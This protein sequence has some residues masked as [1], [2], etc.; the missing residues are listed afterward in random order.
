MRVRLYSTVICGRPSIF[1]TIISA[2]PSTLDIACF[3][4]SAFSASIPKSSPKILI[5]TSERVPEISSLKRISIGCVN[6]ISIFGMVASSSSFILSANSSF[7]LADTHSL[8]GFIFTI[9]SLSSI[10][11]GSVGTSAAPIRLTIW[12]T[13]GNL[14]SIVFS[15][16]V[17]VSMVLARDV[18]VFK[19]G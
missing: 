16:K 13:S 19:T 10:D 2:A 7:D 14:F 15:I 5:A 17:V 4:C 3:I 11:I 1:S 18:P 9:M 12:S 6:S 8:F